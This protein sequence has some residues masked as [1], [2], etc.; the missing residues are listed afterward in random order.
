MPSTS[1]SGACRE[2]RMLVRLVSQL[3]S[4]GGRRQLQ[5]PHVHEAS[6]ES[7]SGGANKQ[8]Q[9]ALIGAGTWATGWHLPHLH[10]HPDANIAA[11]VEVAEAHRAAMGEKYGA[12]TFETIDALIVSGVAVDGVL[13]SAPHRAHFELGK[14]AI[15]AGYNVLIEKPM[16]VS[17]AEAQALVEAARAGGKIFMVNNTANFRDQAKS[18]LELV[19]TI[20][21]V[22]HVQCHMGCAMGDMFDSPERAT[23]TAPV[24][25]AGINGFGWGQL[26]HIMSWVFQVTKLRPAQAFA[27]MR[28]AERTG[29]D[30]SD[31][32][33]VQ[34][35]NGATISISGTSQATPQRGRGKQIDVRIFGSAGMLLYCGDDS[36]PASG[37]LQLVSADADAQEKRAADIP[38]GFYFEET[39]QGGT[40]SES[41][42]TFVDGC[43]GRPYFDGASA[44]VGQAVVQLLEAMYKS[45]K[46]GTAEKVV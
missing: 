15:A 34:C 44:E 41:I 26:S 23:W 32:A 2:H 18:A 28:L 16:T 35:T 42:S 11:I 24:G 30:L 4:S 27:F 14:K 3:V 38:P 33:A 21:E 5:L 19:K 37:S 40:G 12:P 29:A 39:A 13:I 6:A 45:A 20:G 8:A 7:G 9:I 46:S 17:A 25:V 43:L 22:Q 10:A 1:I 31:A 36:D